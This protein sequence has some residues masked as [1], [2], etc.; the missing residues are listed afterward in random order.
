MVFFFN[1]NLVEVS[2]GQAAKRTMC[3]AGMIVMLLL[4]RYHIHVVYIYISIYW[5]MMRGL[6]RSRS[7]RYN[8]RA[9]YRQAIMRVSGRQRVHPSFGLCAMRASMV[10]HT[11]YFSRGD[12]IKS[13]TS[14]CTSLYPPVSPA[15]PSVRPLSESSS[16]VIHSLS[17]VQKHHRATR[18]SR[19]L[20]LN[21]ILLRVVRLT[22][23][24][25]A[26][27]LKRFWSASCHCSTVQAL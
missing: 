1:E 6:M 16:I 10:F 18:S 4:V 22:R 27:C 24:S 8:A 21:E 17:D 5:Y 9:I 26:A 11:R 23:P 20:T 13:A 19:T 14:A 25:T 7:I 15:F 3:S 12:R 2:H